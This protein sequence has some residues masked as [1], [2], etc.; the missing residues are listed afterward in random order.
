[1]LSN[2]K[3]GLRP[4]ASF[5]LERFWSRGAVLWG[6]AGPVR[7]NFRPVIANNAQTTGAESSAQG[8]TAEIAA[9]LVKGDVIYRMALQEFISETQTP[10]EDGAVEWTEEV[11]PSIDVATLVIPQNDRNPIDPEVTGVVDSLAFNPWN[12]PEEFR[13]LGNLM[14]ARKIVYAASA[15]RWLRR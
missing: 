8:L 4:C 1:M 5:A 11:T 9:R 12:A 2:M 13:P 15:E 10:I 6:D 14:R 3:Q 7:F